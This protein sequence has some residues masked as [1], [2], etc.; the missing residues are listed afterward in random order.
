ME[1]DPEDHQPGPAQ[2]LRVPMHPRGDRPP[3]A[4]RQ[5]QRDE[6]E[7]GR[8]QAEANSYGEADRRRDERWPDRSIPPAHDA[9]A[10]RAARAMESDTV[11][12]RP[13]DRARRR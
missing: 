9:R 10:R 5:A 4:H 8:T 6:Q 13:G 2:D 12:S 3:A 1:T 11:S 7:Q